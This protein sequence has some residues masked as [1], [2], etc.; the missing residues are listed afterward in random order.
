MWMDFKTIFKKLHLLS[1]KSMALY[2]TIVEIH[3]H[4]TLKIHRCYIKTISNK[5]N[6]F[7][8]CSISNAS[9][10]RS[11]SLLIFML[12]SKID[13][14][15]LI[16][17]NSVS[18]SKTISIITNKMIWTEW[19]VN[20]IS[21]IDVENWGIMIHNKMY[22]ISQSRCIYV[23]IQTSTHISTKIN[24]F[25]QDFLIVGNIQ[26]VCRTSATTIIIQRF[27]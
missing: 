17:L 24:S 22:H 12:W 9:T 23:G 19:T 5:L 11:F 4:N 21:T 16:N 1:L 8:L 2:R 10:E 13:R 25:L 14:S 3:L 6:L 7:E 26:N 20:K 18:L 15:Q 27:R